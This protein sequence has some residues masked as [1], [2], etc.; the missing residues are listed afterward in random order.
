MSKNY[1]MN[2]Y[3]LPESIEYDDYVI[4]RV[5]LKSETKDSIKM[6]GE[7][8]AE[9]S[10]GSWV[11]LPGVTDKLIETYGAKVISV[12]SVPDYTDKLPDEPRYI[13]IELAYPTI[14]FGYQLPMMFTSIAGIIGMM[15]LKVVD[16]RFPQPFLNELPGPKFGIEGLRSFLNI[17]DRPL[18]LSMIKPCVGLS[19]KE[20]AQLFY[21]VTSGGFDI[22]KDDEKIAGT[23]Y[24]PIV[25]RVKAVMQ[26][27]KQVY[28]ETGNHK[29][30][31]VNITDKPDKMLENA[32]KA[33]EAGANMLMINVLSAGLAALQMVAESDVDLPILGHPDGVGAVS[34]CESR[35][36]SAHLMLGK[37]PRL[38]GSDIIGYGSSHSKIMHT[39]DSNM[40]AALC[41]LSPIKGIKKSFP[42]PAGAVHAGSIKPLIED[43]G[44]DFVIGAGGGVYGHPSGARAG[45]VSIVQAL[46]CIKENK[47]LLEAVKE[48]KELSEAIEKWGFYGDETKTEKLLELKR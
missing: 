7:M 45:A 12:F 23:S 42:M 37:F 27:E 28:E 19:P 6:A 13:C 11:E 16:V 24:S 29:Y 39:Q 18:L 47:S 10:F 21:E 36:W 17:W 2:L 30:Y 14:N 41:M 25:D 1:R 8:A 5:I 35:G 48:H 34:W 46:S 9:Q 43:L 32:R 44:D 38:C 15:H 26:K 33:K 31:A 22:I 4:M 3:Q 40:R 20:T